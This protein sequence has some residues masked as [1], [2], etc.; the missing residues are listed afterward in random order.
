MEYFTKD[1]LVVDD[2][3]IIPLLEGE[4]PSPIRLKSGPRRLLYEMDIVVHKGKEGIRVMK[5][6]HGDSKVS[7][8]PQTLI[9]YILTDNEERRI[10]SRGW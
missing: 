2:T 4:Y 5:N 9:D 6:R 8:L 1:I 3:D 10:I 7:S